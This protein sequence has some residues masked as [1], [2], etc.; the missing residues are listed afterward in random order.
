MDVVVVPLVWQ[1]AEVGPLMELLDRRERSGLVVHHYFPDGSERYR[2]V[3]AGSL[4]EA[5][6]AQVPTVGEVPGGH[7]VQV[8][9]D[10]LARSW[11]LDLVRPGL[12]WERYETMLD[13]HGVQYALVGETSDDVMVVTRHEDLTETLRAAFYQCNGPNWHGFP[14]PRVSIGDPCPRRPECGRPDSTIQAYQG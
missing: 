2:L 10:G 1:E 14:E 13:H 8:V 12:T 5:R 6:R 9:D 11:G 4:M 3:Y 7:D